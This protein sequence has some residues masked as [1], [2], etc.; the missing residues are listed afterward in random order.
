MILGAAWLL[1]ITLS[2]YIRDIQS[3]SRKH[4]RS[5]RLSSL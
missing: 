5:S 4:W 3:G 2:V 1:N